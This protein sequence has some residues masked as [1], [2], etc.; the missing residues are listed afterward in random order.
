MY[1][2]AW[3]SSDMRPPLSLVV[4]HMRHIKQLVG[5]QYIGLGSDFDGFIWLPKEMWDVRDLP[6]LTAAM[7]AGGFSEAEIRGILGENT[8]RVLREIER[9]ATKRPARPTPV[10]QAAAPK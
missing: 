6:K 3:L 1:A 2:P 5:A 4:D 10:L 8:L 9:R 7:A